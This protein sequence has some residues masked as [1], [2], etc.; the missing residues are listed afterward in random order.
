MELI[1]VTW[2]TPKDKTCT[3]VLLAFVKRLTID[4]FL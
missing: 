2:N 1:K 4:L 3:F